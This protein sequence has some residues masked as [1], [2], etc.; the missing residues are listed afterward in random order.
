MFQRITYTIL[1][2]LVLAIIG[3]GGWYAYKNLNHDFVYDSSG[4]LASNEHDEVD[5]NFDDNAQ[6]EA[7]EVSEE[8]LAA[9]LEATTSGQEETTSSSSSTSS[10]HAELVRRLNGLIQDEIY[11]KVGSRGTRVGTVQEFLNI[12]LD[13]QSGVD[14]DFGPGTKTRVEQFQ[15]TEGLTADGQ[16][17][18]ATY[19]AMIDW[20]NKQ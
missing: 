1:W 19:Q 3:V 10:E 20:L 16:P 6:P 13:A 15:K 17:G 7:P 18:P 9:A 14:N 2:L 8:E 12:Y 11:M 5:L 4:T